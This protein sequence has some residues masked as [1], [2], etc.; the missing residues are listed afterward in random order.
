MPFD[1]KL[2]SQMKIFV[3]NDSSKM[4]LPS[5]TSLGFCFLVFGFF[6]FVCFV[7]VLNFDFI[8]EYS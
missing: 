1:P 6:L 5:H 3:L 4:D 8:L 7:F 2:H